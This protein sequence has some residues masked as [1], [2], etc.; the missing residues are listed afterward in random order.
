MKEKKV[1]SSVVMKYFEWQPIVLKSKEGLAYLMVL[2]S[3]SVWSFIS[4]KANK[5]SYLADLIKHFSMML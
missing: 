3:M 5:L 4:I 2:N 1:A